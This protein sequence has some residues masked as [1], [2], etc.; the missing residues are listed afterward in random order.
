M[1]VTD[2][3]CFEGEKR[4]KLMA[5]EKFKEISESVAVYGDTTL[6]VPLKGG[7]E[8]LKKL[9]DEHYVVT[10]FEGCFHPSYSSVCKHSICERGV[11]INA[12]TVTDPEPEL[13]K[14]QN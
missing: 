12:M 6:P 7:K 11:S 10:F 2:D 13:E 4:H 14:Q 9:S 3:H 1:I 5:D 8:L